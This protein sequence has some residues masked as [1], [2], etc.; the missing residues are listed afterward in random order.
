MVVYTAYVR[1]MG[2]LTQPRYFPGADM[3]KFAILPLE[4]AKFMVKFAILH[5]VLNQT[6][7][8]SLAYHN[9]RTN[10][11][12]SHQSTS[13]ATLILAPITSLHH[14]P[15]STNHQS[16]PQ[17]SRQSSQ[18]I[19]ESIVSIPPVSSWYNIDTRFVD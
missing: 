5:L 17:S 3:A 9:L 13:L 8:Y 2:H 11:H 16:L 6:P 15:R 19:A 10:D 18:Y 7:V 4:L 14:N 1:F 12:S